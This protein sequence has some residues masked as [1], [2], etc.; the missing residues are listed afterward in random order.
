MSLLTSKWFVLAVAIGVVVLL[1]YALGRKSVHTELEIPATPAMV[2]QVLTDTAAYRDWNPVLVPV[3]G[4]LQVGSRVEYE[5]TQDEG[6]SYVIPATVNRMNAGSL[7]NQGGGTPVILTFDHRYVLEP[8]DGGTKVTIH[9]DYRG[10]GVHFW[11]PSPVQA[12]YER[13]NA[14]LKDRVLALKKPGK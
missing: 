13:L 7:L 2:W 8:V 12:A 9:E 1:M 14:A 4:E 11:D 5:F 10:I 3:K 6:N